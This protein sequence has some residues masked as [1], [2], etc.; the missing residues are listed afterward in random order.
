MT[1]LADSSRRAGHRR[2]KD[3]SHSVSEADL[4]MFGRSTARHHHD[5]PSSSHVPRQRVN[6]SRY[7]NATFPGAGYGVGSLVPLPSDADSFMS[8]ESHHSTRSH[9]PRLQSSTR[10]AASFATPAT[11]WALPHQK[12]NMVEE[13]K[14]PSIG[15]WKIEILGAVISGEAVRGYVQCRVENLCVKS[16]SERRSKHLQWNFET[17]LP[18]SDVHRPLTVELCDDDGSVQASSHFDPFDFMSEETPVFME[19]PLRSLLFRG[20][21]QVKL[22]V[23]LHP[24]ARSLLEKSS[25]RAENYAPSTSRLPPKP[26]SNPPGKPETSGSGPASAAGR[27]RVSFESAIGHQEVVDKEK[28]WKD[29]NTISDAPLCAEEV[30]TLVTSLQTLASETETLR[31]NVYE[32]EL[33][34]SEKGR[35]IENMSSMF[36]SGQAALVEKVEALETENLPGQLAE[37]EKFSMEME[38]DMEGVVTAVR[39]LKFF[40][41]SMEVQIN[42][43][44]NKVAMLD[45]STTQ[46]SQQVRDSYRRINLMEQR[47]G[48][49]WMEWGLLIA[50]WV[51]K[52]VSFFILLLGWIST[53]V[54]W[55]L[56]ACG[57]LDAG[58]ASGKVSSKIAHTTLLLSDTANEF[59][60]NAMH[61]ILSDKESILSGGQVDQVHVDRMQ[62]DDAEEELTLKQSKRDEA[63]LFRRA[64]F[65]VLE[66]TS[67]SNQ[68]RSKKG[69]G[70]PS[71]NGLSPFRLSRRLS[72][73]RFAHRNPALDDVHDPDEAHRS[74][75]DEDSS[76]LSSASSGRKPLRSRRTHASYVTLGDLHE[77]QPLS[78][79]SILSHVS[80]K[81]G[82]SEAAES[83]EVN[84]SAAMRLLDSHTRHHPS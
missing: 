38:N 49:T 76:T 37:M 23:Q 21:L 28:M 27:P 36:T 4:D 2:H 15:F 59:R 66:R 9:E 62:D 1:M 24:T 70:K 68:G 35:Q 19:V 8:E 64:G 55:I 81:S 42:R 77:D 20:T 26:H 3:P 56:E 34:N 45:S 58:V 69:K 51:L 63:Q 6:T 16:K 32:L 61:N 14:S 60:K 71:G 47:L 5:M 41:S 48:R 7:A 17:T 30:K 74:E 11:E 33:Q 40:K 12:K 52:G 57:C 80:S 54:L 39:E 78:N 67:D 13:P 29:L 46:L 79:H 83:K 84:K 43:M 73:N 75:S 72:H 53:K 65:E 44:Q 82:S 25:A 18:V 31:R 10:P 50:S 22:Q